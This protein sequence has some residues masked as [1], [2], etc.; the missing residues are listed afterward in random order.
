MSVVTVKIRYRVFKYIL[1]YKEIFACLKLDIYKY[2]LLLKYIFACLELV[3]VR[4]R[5]RV[6]V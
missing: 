2:N 4:N 5:F 3:Y 6:K 1:L